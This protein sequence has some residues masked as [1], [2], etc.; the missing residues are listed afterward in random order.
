[1]ARQPIYN[2]K[3]EVHAYELLFRRDEANTAGDLD[4]ETGAQSLVSTLVDIGL[5]DLIGDST[6]FINV[7]QELLLSN[8]VLMLPIDQVVLEILETVQPTPEV[9]L[10]LVEL[11][12]LGYKIALDDFVLNAET[13]PLVPHASLIKVDV[14]GMSDEEIRRASSKIRKPGLQ[15]L[16]EK[17]ETGAQFKTCQRLGF[18]LFQGYYFSKPEMMRGS[19]IQSNQIALLRLAAKIQAPNAQYSELEE[20]IS[21]DVTLSYR[22]LKFVSSAHLGLGHT[23]TSVRQALMFLG[24]STV[25][26]LAT[27]LAM[28]GNTSKPHELLT[29]ALVRAK[30][31]EILAK[32]RH[33]SHTDQYF[34]VGL[35]SVL[36]A[37]LNAPMEAVLAEL[38]LSP[39]INEALLHVDCEN[40][41]AL[42]LRSALAYE[43]GDWDCLQPDGVSAHDVSNAYHAAVCWASEAN[44]QMAA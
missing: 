19:S 25:A 36:D 2:A 4:A 6:A 7:S 5:R 28:A 13:A 10:R 21:S 29:T 3:L 42:T 1:M 26:A 12:N 22:L 15:L 44:Q 16:A 30:M 14:L 11:K 40:D 9:L 31:C 18:E 35:L 38:P 33:Q 34:T 32:Q 41:L 39:G 27:L 23:I 17:V 24:V 8:S 43:Q 20:I 37:L